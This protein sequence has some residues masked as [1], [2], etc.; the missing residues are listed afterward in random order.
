ML[1]LCDIVSKSGSI[2]L[3]LY[4][5]HQRIIGYNNIGKLLNYQLYQDK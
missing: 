5:Y 3:E 4:L 2:E 1:S